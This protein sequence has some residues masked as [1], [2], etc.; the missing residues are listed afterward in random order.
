MAGPRVFTLLL[1]L[2]IFAGCATQSGRSLRMTT[3]HVENH[4]LEY[5]ALVLTFQVGAAHDPKGKEGLANLAANMLLRG[6]SSHSREALADE[7]DFIGTSIGINVGRETTQLFVDCATRNLPKLI[8][9]LEEVLVDSTFPKDEFEKL[10]RQTVAELSEMRDSDGDVARL[11]FSELIFEGHPYAHPTQGYESTV[12]AVTRDEAEEFY[13]HY[14][15]RTDVLVGIA[16]DVAADAVPGIRRQLLAKLPAG[17]NTPVTP[18][19]PASGPGLRVLLV[20]RPESTQAQVAIGQTALRG[21]SPDLFPATVAVTGFGGTFT[22]VLVR[23]IREVR[24]WSYGVGAALVPG[25]HTGLFK[26]SYAPSTQDVVPAIELTG[27]LLRDLAG[28]GLAEE[29]IKFAQGY[30]SSQYPFMLDTPHKR[31]AMA[32]DVVLA[33]KPDDYVERYVD[34][35]GGVTVEEARRVVADLLRPDDLAIVVVGDSALAKGLAGLPGVVSFRQVS[36]TWEGPLPVATEPAD[37]GPAGGP[38]K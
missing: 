1:V 33:N 4:T 38:A 24:G 14:F 37:R 29:H 36:A 8:D 6:T 22:S 34:Y 18:A 7:L 11:F 3:V 31:L 27:E 20:T 9:L 12:A 35:V 32:M 13:R 16:G 5:V 19:V 2:T 21:D 26:V 28:K 30:L 23:E 15:T 10:Q 17:R 25:R